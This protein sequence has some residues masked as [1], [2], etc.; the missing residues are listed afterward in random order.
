MKIKSAYYEIDHKI[1]KSLPNDS[2]ETIE[3]YLNFKFGFNIFY[4]QN[5]TTQ[6]MIIMIKADSYQ[7]K[8]IDFVFSSKM[9]NNDINENPKQLD[10]SVHKSTIDNSNE[11]TQVKS[12]KVDNK[13]ERKGEPSL[14]ISNYLNKNV[15]IEIQNGNI[16]DEKV[17]AIVNA[18]NVQLQLGGMNIILFS[19]YFYFN[20]K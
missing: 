19:L 14:K 6:K 1:I 17:N 10:Q 16:L 12:V 18:A 9:P 5:M 20:I 3:K 11:K 15:N 7:K 8:L 2:V 4:F 13:N